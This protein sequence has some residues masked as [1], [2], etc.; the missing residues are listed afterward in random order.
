MNIGIIVYS[1]TGNT[2]SVA[3]RLQERLLKN[4]HSVNLE[5]VETVDEKQTDPS[6]IRLKNLP[7]VGGHDALVFAGPVWAF[8]LSAVMSIYLR[9]L[10]TLGGK[11]IACFVTMAFPYAWLGGNRAIAKMKKICESKGGKVSGTGIINWMNKRREEQIAG[12]VENLSGLF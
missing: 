8:S 2:Y 3:Q 12:L 6:K 7:E 5:R 1:Q 9:Q 11:K 4:G 10:S